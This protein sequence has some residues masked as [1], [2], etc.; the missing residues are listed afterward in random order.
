MPNQADEIRQHALTRHVLPWRQL[1]NR[2][3]AIRAGDIV[4]EMKLQ[5]ATPNV[6]SALEGRKFQQEAGLSLI[7]RSGPRRSTTTTFLYQS[8]NTIPI[9]SA[10]TDTN[11]TVLPKPRRSSGVQPGA[12]RHHKLPRA[13]LYLVSCVSTKLDIP[14]P[15]KNLYVS[16]WFLKARVCVEATALPWF[17]L[18]AK[19]GLVA[20]NE[21]IQPYNL[22]L[23]NMGVSQRR[24]WAEPV[25]EA[26]DE[27]L[28]GVDS[29][30]FLAGKAY[31]ENLAPAFRQR[32]IQV[33]VPME[34]LRNG[35]QLSWLNR[36]IES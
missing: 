16:S 3:L 9:C 32:G 8:C 35:Q 13:G 26:L 4:R 30:V 17:I 10:N 12:L 33:L 36:C 22:T 1:D 23:R 24:N 6:C 5:N 7:G 21:V 19:Y 18:S 25:I 20:P 34:G 14:A 15:A 28:D 2:Q 27:H 29:V 11:T 31:R